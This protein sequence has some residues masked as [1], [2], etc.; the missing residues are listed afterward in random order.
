MSDSEVDDLGAGKRFLERV[1]DMFSGEPTSRSE[2]METLRFAADR[3]LIDVDVLNI[4][5]GAIGLSEMHARDVMI[6]RSRL[7]C[8]RAD[9]TPKQFLPTIVESQHSRFPVIGDD[10][11]DVRGIL[12]AKDILAL[13]TKDNWDDFDIKDCMRPA[14]VIP[15]S[16]RL[17]VLLQDFRA[18]RNHMAVVI[19]EYGHISGAVTIEDV[20]EQIVGDIDDEH[21]VDDRGDVK[22][23]GGDNYTVKATTSIVDFNER[24]G[25]EFSGAEFD[26]IGGLVMKHFGHLPKRDEAIAMGDLMFEV[27]NADSRRIR[28]MRVYPVVRDH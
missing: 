10:V 22:E 2:L 11:D 21:D 23:L 18:N 28:L 19:D 13:L 12:H 24:F 20:L 6:P 5:F 8:V 17:N 7:V 4:L 1:A 9:A 14:A 15:E 16:K 25:T 26:T 3:D 27:L